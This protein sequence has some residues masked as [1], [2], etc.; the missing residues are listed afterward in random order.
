LSTYPRIELR[1]HKGFS[2]H[3]KAL[4]TLRLQKISADKKEFYKSASFQVCIEI[5]KSEPQKQYKR[6]CR[7][8]Y[9]RRRIFVK[10]VF[11]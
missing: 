5:D 8:E 3:P 10:K 4:R 6:S 1:F 11:R 9:E 7:P 2:S